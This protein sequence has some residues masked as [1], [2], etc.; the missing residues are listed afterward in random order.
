MFNKNNSKEEIKLKFT[1]EKNDE[2]MLDKKDEKKKTTKTTRKKDVDETVKI[3]KKETSK[4]TA[5]KAITKTTEK[6]LMEIELEKLE[7]GSWINIDSPDIDE[8]KEISNATG[9]Q[10]D[11]LTAALDEEE[12]SRVEIEDDQ[13]LILV[14]I[15]FFRSNKDYDTMPLGI[16]VTNDYLVTVCLEPN[17]VTADFGEH[18]AR[19]FSTFKRT[20]FMFQILFKSATLYLKYIRI[21]IRRTDE[22]EKH[23][24]QS[25]ENNELFNLL[26]L[27]KSLTYFSTSLRSN[28]IVLERLLR[29]RNTTASHGIIK[30]YE[31]DEDLQ[32]DVIIEYKQ[33]LEMVETPNCKTIA[34]VCAFLNAPVDKSMKAVAFSSE[35][36]LILCF[37]RG[38]HEV[39]EIKV[40]NTV[41]VNEVEMADESLLV[42]AGTVGGYMGP[43]GL[44]PEKVT[45]V[46]DQSVMKMH[47]ICCGANKEGY[48]YVNANPGRDFKPTFVADIR[49]AQVGDPCPHCGAKM[50][51]ARGIE[52]G[53]VFKLFTKYSKAMN[54]TFLDENGKEQPM[55]MGC[56]G[57]GVGRTMAACVEQ[58]FDKD[59]II[60]PVSIAP[61]EVLV[62]PVNAKDKESWD[63]AFEIYEALKKAGVEAVI[64]D[65]N[66]R[67]GVKFKDADL[68]G[69]P[70]RVVVGPKTIK[71][72]NL[73]VKARK[74]GEVS[75]LPMDSDY[76]ATIVDMLKQL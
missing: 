12:K 52:A 4:K 71:E 51:K 75:M 37:V 68:I 17:A 44:D 9:I 48:H 15:P 74:T 6:G 50:E 41:G 24:R 55:Y 46:I 59:G 56:Y 76:I 66:E 53:Q 21:I 49:L 67:P 28:T 36:G 7:K 34:D 61:Y 16:I 22:L 35:K 3:D 30:I 26:D 31:E 14:D 25:M 38:D 10:M 60:W 20:R 11:F 69:Y 8:L 47:N 19:L 43:V 63:K 70:L 1:K 64:D 40:A 45:I 57:I 39:N 33:A 73:E 13:I 72:G 2:E 29:L 5:K 18:N 65:R 58:S 32:D 23:L 27:Q 62:V 42:E 54:A